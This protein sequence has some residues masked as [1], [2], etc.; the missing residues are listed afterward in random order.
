MLR[1]INKSRRDEHGFTLIEL[2]MVLVI[3][4]IL[5][6]LA[7]P[8]YL[9]TRRKADLSEAQQTLQEMRTNAWRYYAEHNMFG[10]ATLTAPPPTGN[11]TWAYGTC[12][13]TTCTMT[14]TGAGPVIGAVVQLVLDNTGRGTLS[15]SGF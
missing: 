2:I 15:S 3:L 11:W 8:A 14:A 6:A 9:R 7:L 5:L 12:A 13:G 10:T 4:G 1:K